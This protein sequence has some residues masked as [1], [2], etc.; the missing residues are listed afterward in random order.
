VGSYGSPTL[1]HFAGTARIESRDRSLGRLRVHRSF[2]FMKPPTKYDCSFR[3]K[4]PSVL[5]AFLLVAAIPAFAQAGAS[6]WENAVSVLQTAFTSTIARGLS[7]VAIVVAGL[8]F[9]FA[10]SRQ[11]SGI[12]STSLCTSSVALAGASSR[13][14]WR[15][16]A[17]IPTGTSTTTA[18][19]S[20]ATRN[21][22]ECRRK[23]PFSVRAGIHS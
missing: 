19:F 18:S 21:C 6:P 7:L 10:Q 4:R 20:T 2:F 23:A 8:T 14:S 11:T 1:V 22:Y 12:R 3:A 15:S 13:R 16:M 5:F 9:A 17:T